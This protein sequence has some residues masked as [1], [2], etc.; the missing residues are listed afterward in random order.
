[1]FGSETYRVELE[2]FEG[3]LDLLLF[4]IQREE[5]DIYDIPIARITQQYLEFLDLMRSLDLDVAGEYILLASTLIAIKSRTLL[6]VPEV[7]EEGEVIDP[8]Q[9]LVRQLLEYRRF[10]AAAER[11]GDIEVTRRGI[12]GRGDGAAMPDAPAAELDL[13]LYELLAAYHR[14]LNMAAV[15]E[16]ARPVVELETVRIED[17]VRMIRHRLERSPRLRLSELI[18]AAPVRLHLIVTFMAILELVRLGEVG[19]RQPNAFDEVYLYR[20]ES[21][22][23]R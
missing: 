18:G 4:L 15:R 11:I 5:V 14:A 9:E 23:D 2:H 22:Y 7:D 13:G 20:R 17:Q 16:A 6:P 19:A 8:R 21:T 3:P 12:H 1:M 10:R